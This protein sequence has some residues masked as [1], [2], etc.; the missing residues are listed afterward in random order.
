MDFFTAPDAQL[1]RWLSYTARQNLLEGIRARA[2]G[3]TSGIARRD[4]RGIPTG[5]EPNLEVN[6]LLLDN[7][8][9]DQLRE[10]IPHLQDPRDLT[11]SANAD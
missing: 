8:V 9:R 5:F 2:E 7:K 4:A 3:E 10:Q 6:R 1:T 11:L